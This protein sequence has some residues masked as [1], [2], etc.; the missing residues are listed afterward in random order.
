LLQSL[1][2]GRYRANIRYK[3]ESPA[4][5]RGTQTTVELT[6][7]EDFDLSALMNRYGDDLVIL[8]LQ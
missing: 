3:N 5:H 1:P 7:G 6:R 2:D 8:R 4:G